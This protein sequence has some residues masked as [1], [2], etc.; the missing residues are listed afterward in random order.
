LSHEENDKIQDKEETQI[1]MKNVQEETEDYIEKQLET[2]ETEKEQYNP[3]EKAI[4][5]HAVCESVKIKCRV[6]FA[7]VSYIFLNI[8]TC[9]LLIFF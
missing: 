9:F 3:L 1:L 4:E 7:V 2:I 8:K 6:F 5:E